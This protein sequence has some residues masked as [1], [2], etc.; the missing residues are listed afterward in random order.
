MKGIILLKIFSVKKTVEAVFFYLY[1]RYQCSKLYPH[2][3]YD[4]STIDLI[5]H[6][7]YDFNE[8]EKG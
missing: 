3:F 5:G 1:A 6:F 7:D 8:L 2:L 4:Q